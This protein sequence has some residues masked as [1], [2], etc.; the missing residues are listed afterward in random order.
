MTSNF[1]AEQVLGGKKARF[2]SPTFFGK[3][4]PEECFGFFFYF[5]VSTKVLKN[6]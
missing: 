2:K 5:G 3:E 4:H 1:M 6:L